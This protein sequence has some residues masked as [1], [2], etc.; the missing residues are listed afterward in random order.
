MYDEA[1]A[2]TA[3]PSSERLLSIIELQNAIAAAALNADEV[4]RFVADRAASS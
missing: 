1:M 4:M 3:T 2:D